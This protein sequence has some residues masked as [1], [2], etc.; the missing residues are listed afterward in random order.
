VREEV[1]SSISPWTLPGSCGTTSVAKFQFSKREVAMQGP[2][3]NQMQL[4]GKI[5]GG[6]PHPD[7]PRSLYFVGLY[8]PLSSSFD[9]ST[10]SNYSTSAIPPL[11]FGSTFIT[12]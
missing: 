6:S 1:F 8:V 11:L 2:L 10:S 12:V 4:T 9:Y 5:A 7:R 3:A